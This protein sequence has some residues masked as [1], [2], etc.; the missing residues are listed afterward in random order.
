MYNAH[1][2]DYRFTFKAVVKFEFAGTAR[3]PRRFH[4]FEDLD[5][6]RF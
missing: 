3:K 6:A 1:I 2:V 5:N 4:A